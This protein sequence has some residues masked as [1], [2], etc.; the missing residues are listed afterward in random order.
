MKRFQISRLALLAALWIA[1]G[2]GCRPSDPDGE[3]GTEPAPAPPP[4]AAP[5]L[6]PAVPQE[7]AGLTSDQALTSDAAPA[8]ALPAGRPLRAGFLVVNGVYNT[9]LMAPYDVFQHTKF[10]SQPGIEVFTVSPDGQ[11]VTTFEGIRIT[12]TYG[13]QNA[14]AMDI[15]VVPSAEGSMDRDLQ[16]AALIDW[17]RQVGG[18]ARHVMSLCDGAFLLAKAGLLNGVP[19][20]T[21][22]KDY[23]RFSTMFPDVD[24]RI[25]VSFVDAGR[26]LTSQGGAR[27]YDVA[28]HLVDRLYGQRVAKGIGEGLL[29]DWPPDPDTMVPRVVLSTPPAP[30][31]PT[32]SEAPTVPAPGQP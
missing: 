29:I 2:A 16:N 7:S 1:V 13:F 12:P 32:A 17:V 23:E 25:N 9:E 24:L 28:M 26:M 20:T 14:P 27:S 5:A 18:Q 3:A 21:F 4:A 11:P 6:A 31:A 10:H 22:P 8:A 19:A 30:A 15:L